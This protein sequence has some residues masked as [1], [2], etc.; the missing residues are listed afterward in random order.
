MA[1]ST[2]YGNPL[3]RV[4]QAYPPGSPSLIVALEAICSTA[5]NHGHKKAK[6]ELA[7]AVC[8]GLHEGPGTG[9]KCL[10]CYYAETQYAGVQ[11]V[12]AEMEIIA[13]A[14]K[15]AGGAPL[16]VQEAPKPPEDNLDPQLLANVLKDLGV[17]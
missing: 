16:P 5:E 6:Q 8:E 3:V 14:N 4:L 1:F 10:D 9:L 12:K 13:A 15:E 11:Q 17:E 7:E 2:R